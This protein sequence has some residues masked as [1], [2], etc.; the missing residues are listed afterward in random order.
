MINP[1]IITDYN[2][3]SWMQELPENNGKIFEFEFTMDEQGL[4]VSEM[5]VHEEYRK[6]GVGT[7]VILLAKEMYGNILFSD[8][9]HGNQEN[10]DKR[11]LT[12]DGK[13]FVEGLLKNGIITKESYCSP[14]KLLR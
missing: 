8:L 7:K 11:Y 14:L 1:K 2:I 10:Y 9:E 6:R 4:W 12:C 3:I 13:M 5:H